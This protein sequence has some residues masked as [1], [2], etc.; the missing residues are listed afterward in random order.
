MF[1]TEYPDQW[2]SVYYRAYSNYR[3]LV[4]KGDGDQAERTVNLEAIKAAWT[5]QGY[6][7]EDL[8]RSPDYFPWWT[9]TPPPRTLGG[10][11]SNAWA[12]NAR[13]TFPPG[14]AR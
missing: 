13:T 14:A 11:P 8:P 7:L 12:S 4:C 10:R 5:E 9:G 6:A 3:G 1:P 2:A